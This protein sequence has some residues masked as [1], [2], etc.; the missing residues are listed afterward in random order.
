MSVSSLQTVRSIVNQFGPIS[1]DQ[2][3]TV[4]LMD[5]I[6]MKFILPFDQ[7]VEL[8]PQ[9]GQNYNVL[10]ID[11]NRVF[12]Y[13]TDY[14]DTPG[15]NMYY[16][17][18]NGR[19]TRFKIR[20]REY[21]ESRLAF[22]EVKFRSNK[23]RII[24]ERIQYQNPNDESF[25]GFIEKHTPYNPVKLQCNVIN[26]FNRFTLVDHE[27]H[28]RVTADF[29]IS[30]TDRSRNISLRGL[31]IIEIKQAHE[32]KTSLIYQVMKNNHIRPSSISKYCIGVTLLNNCSKANNFK[33]ILLQ[34]NK[35]SHVEFTT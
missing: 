10:T 1:L 23:G 22:L 3:D 8:L 29:N 31:V 7:F 20:H 13:Q 4:K 27:M 25:E 11:G 30:F 17:H 34:I 2:M 21:I 24:K 16:D 5:R 35:I 9:L 15:L 19:L 18:H 26:H 6:D 12:S 14:Y 32:D 33:H 28:E